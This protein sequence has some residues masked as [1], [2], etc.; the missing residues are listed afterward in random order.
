VTKSDTK[1]SDDP[2]EEFCGEDQEEENWILGDIVKK[3]D[4]KLEIRKGK[5]VERHDSDDD[6]DFDNEEDDDEVDEKKEKER[7]LS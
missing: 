1:Y 4:I 2:L 7:E 3:M 5:E 6:F